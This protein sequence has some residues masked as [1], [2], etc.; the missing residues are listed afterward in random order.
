MAAPVIVFY[1]PHNRRSRMV[2]AAMER[3]IRAA[4]FRTRMTPSTQHRNAD[5]GDFA[6]FYGL[7]DGL[8]RVLRA[9]RAS[10]RR[11]VYMDLG[12][13]DR[14]K[15]NRY[16]GNHKLA[17]NDRHPTPFLGGMRRSPE[18]FESLGL[19]IEPWQDPTR[20]HIVI[21]GM[22]AKGAR[23]EGYESQQWERS[24]VRRLRQFTDR[25]IVYRPKPNWDGA[26]PIEGTKFERKVPLAESLRGAWAVVTHH[27]N[28]GVDAIL[29]G[30]P[31][32]T[33]E[34][35]ATLMGHTDLAKIESPRRPANRE[36]FLWNLAHWQY[37]VEEMRRGDAWRFLV[38]EGIVP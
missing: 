4:G 3:G 20:G 7:A 36:Q 29:A 25:R 31:V 24:A 21:A 8:D 13:W 27:S 37:D 14:R 26:S 9:Y 28:V 2:G 10:G 17:V 16:D 22:S 18:R 1:A 6:V 34:G 5:M 30:I 33:D 15:R 19:T 12:W 11:A 23:A 38:E 35:V 32:F